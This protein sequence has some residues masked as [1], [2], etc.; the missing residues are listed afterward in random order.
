MREIPWR[1]VRSLSSKKDRDRAGLTVAEGPPSTLSALAS[2]VSIEFLAVSDSYARSDGFAPIEQ[3]LERRSPEAGS[4]EMLT[5]PDELFERMAETRTPQGILCV[6]RFPFRY[7]G[8]PPASP[9]PAPLY[10]CGVD[11]QDP[12]N[13]GTL[14]RAAAAAG[15]SRAVFAG[16]SV[17]IYSP[18]CIRS[19][20]GAAFGVA[21]EHLDQDASVPLLLGEWSGQGM[22]VLKTVPRDGAL[23]WEADMRG[24]AAIVVGSE[25]RGLPRAVIDGPGSCVS[26]PMPGGTES[27]NVAM[28]STA[29]LYEAVRQRM[30]YNP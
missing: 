24:P 11:V 29:V 14:I 28:A 23:P 6:M 8:G 27:L 21:L 25:A 12:G 30:C 9:W 18:K 17:D 22:N 26:I 10:L 20:A 7:P 19:S 13:A 2:G 1:L 15:A 3:A 5:V 4:P 16:E